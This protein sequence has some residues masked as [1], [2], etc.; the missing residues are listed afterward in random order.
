[1]MRNT[2][3]SLLLGVSLNRSAADALVLPVE[4]LQELQ[5]PPADNSICPPTWKPDCIGSFQPQ[6]VGQVLICN[7]G[8]LIMTFVG[9]CV[10]CRSGGLWYPLRPMT[11]EEITHFILTGQVPSS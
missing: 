6:C 10:Q 11:K 7:A 5:S 8:G 2:L 3:F 4:G 1:M 9:I